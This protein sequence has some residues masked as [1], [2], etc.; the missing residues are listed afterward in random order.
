MAGRSRS[1]AARRWRPWPA[2]GAGAPLAAHQ[3][4]WPLAARQAGWPRGWP[5]AGLRGWRGP[6]PLAAML[7][8]LGGLRGW[9]GLAPLAGLVGRLAWRAGTARV[10]PR[11]ARLARG[12]ARRLAR[13]RGRRAGGTVSRRCG[14]ML[15][16]GRCGRPR[17]QR[18]PGGPGATWRWRGGPGPLRRGGP[19]GGC[20]LFRGCHVMRLRPGHVAGP[21]RGAH[22][23]LHA[24]HA[25]S[26]PSVARPLRGPAAAEGRRISTMMSS[27]FIDAIEQTHMIMIMRGRPGPARW[28]AGARCRRGR[29]SW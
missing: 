3:A 14:A 21:H 23:D 18:G 19:G 5:P 15:G 27:L 25:A 1:P 12:G 4:G 29:S 22:R 11:R 28:C 20:V 16:G 9:R 13:P 6:A 2:C 8:R 24:G 7:A 10:M 26:P 17:G